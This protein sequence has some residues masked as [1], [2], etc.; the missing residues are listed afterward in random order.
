MTRALLLLLLAVPSGA[1]ELE[2]DAV[3]ARAAELRQ[4][5]RPF[6]KTMVDLDMVKRSAQDEEPDWVSEEKR[7]T[8]PPERP[9]AR[10]AGSVLRRAD[11]RYVI[12]G[13]HAPVKEKEKVK[14]LRLAEGAAAAELW[15][16]ITED[17]ERRWV[18]SSTAPG[19]DAF[20]TG[21]SLRE[22]PNHAAWSPLDWYREPGA[23]GEFFVLL[24]ADV[25]RGSHA[26]PA[27][28]EDHG[29]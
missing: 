25:P 1:W 23:K 29:G 13:R 5:W 16:L 28:G 20:R 2:A 11:V 9:F 21:P 17:D 26:A 14:A 3:D 7:K 27:E 6:N 22:R 24:F 4:R 12:V 8:A 15:R 19:R 18:L 10:M